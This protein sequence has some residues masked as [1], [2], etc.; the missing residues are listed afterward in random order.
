MF[1][2]EFKVD[3]K[4][5]EIAQKIE[6]IYQDKDDTLGSRLLAKMLGLSRKT[7]I[8]VMQKY[9]ISA[10]TSKKAYKYAGKADQTFENFFL[11][12]KIKTTDLDK[13]EIIFSDIFEFR[14]ADRSKV[15]CCFALRKK[16]RQ[17]ISFVYSYSRP[18][19]L[20]TNTIT[21]MYNIS[22]TNLFNLKDTKAIWHTDQGSQ[23]GASMT[24]D[25]LLE[26]GFTISMSRAGTL[27]DNPFAERFVGIFKLAVVQKQ[28]YKT[29]GDFIQKAE[30]WLNFYNDE[31]SHSSLDYLSPNQF[32]LKK[33]LE[34]ISYLAVK[35]V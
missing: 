12:E 34:N 30:N 21:Q 11:Q 35:G 24:V 29:I 18:A 19:Q 27:T 14:L 6:E 10:R 33:H 17:I 23:Y 7:I 4:D 31:R 13:Y 20:V 8:R 2:Y 3:K 22:H 26:L 28:K 15:Y 5:R 25:K 16:T 1:Y 9:G 32:A